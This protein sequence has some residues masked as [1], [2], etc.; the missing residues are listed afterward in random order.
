MGV[1]SYINIKIFLVSFLLGVILVYLTA[2]VHDVVYKF[3]SP[4][5]VGKFT[6]KNEA[7]N[8]C[9]KFIAK[10]VPCENQHFLDQPLSV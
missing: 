7:D 1:S 3:P 5:N 4:D 2:P 8:S 10:T 6:Y 9:Y